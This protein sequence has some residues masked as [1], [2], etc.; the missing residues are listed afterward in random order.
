MVNSKDPRFAGID[1]SILADDQ[2]SPEDW[3]NQYFRIED[4]SYDYKTDGIRRGTELIE[5]KVAMSRMRLA[6][7]NHDVADIKYMLQDAFLVWR[8]TQ[9]RIALDKLRKQLTYKQNCENLI[10]QWVTAVT[11]SD[12]VLDLAVMT[13]FIWQVKRKLFSS[14]VE[15]HMMPI[16]YGKTGGGK[17]V[18][19]QNFIKPLEEVTLTT[20]MSVF[21]DRFGKRQFTRNFIMFF[22]ELEGSSGVDINKLKQVVTS[23]VMEWR[24]MH[25]EGTQSATQNCTFIG[26]TNDP[27]RDR[28][29]DP[30]SARRFWQINCADKLDW[31]FINSIDYLSLWQSIDEN[32]QCPL[33][34]YIDQ[35]RKIQ[36]EEIRAKDPIE[37]WLEQA[38]RP[39][40]FYNESPTT[41]ILYDYFKNWCQWQGVNSYPGFQA[42]ARK[43]QSCINLLGWDVTSRHS[44]EGTIWSLKV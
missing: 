13:H 28:I 27:V 19:V 5:P 43:I 33:L 20:N 44:S 41:K 22:D 21:Q 17:S 4:I 37:Q 39:H 15:H 40:P 24:V 2:L 3:I 1:T 8:H 6:A 36:E 16:L 9:V 25:S 32:K 18:A 12:S 23:P 29:A 14:S 10:A 34:P 38:C 11:G 26:C 7:F 30:T 31:S 42:F 35:I